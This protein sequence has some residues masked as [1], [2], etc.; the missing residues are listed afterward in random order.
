MRCG[1][2]T[3]EQN[4]GKSTLPKWRRPN[5][6]KRSS[7]KNVTSRNR[8]MRSHAATT[9]TPNGRAS[10]CI[11]TCRIIDSDL[12]PG[13][14]PMPPRAWDQTD[15]YKDNSGSVQYYYN[16]D[17]KDTN[18]AP[19]DL[20]NWRYDKGQKSDNVDS[21]DVNSDEPINFAYYHF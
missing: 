17:Y 6:N 10:T 3:E 18:D 8:T 19:C 12:P 14:D 9:T 21:D 1:S 5:V 13:A 15:T 2:R 20:S 11:C 16:Y 7:G 4:G